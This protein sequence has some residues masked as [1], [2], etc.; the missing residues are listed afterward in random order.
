M[1]K[2]TLKSAGLTEEEEE[3]E[4]EEEGEEPKLVPK[5][6]PEGT[7]II[8]VGSQ[9]DFKHHPQDSQS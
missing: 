5:R 6:N 9:K 2:R 3:E 8:Q 4:E 7:Q 1:I